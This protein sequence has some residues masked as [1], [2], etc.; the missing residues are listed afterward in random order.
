MKYNR[1]GGGGQKLDFGWMSLYHFSSKTYTLFLILTFDLTFTVTG[2][3][4]GDN[5]KPYCE[6]HYDQIFGVSC[7]VCGA[8]VKDNESGVGEAK[9]ATCCSRCAKHDGV[10]MRLTNGNVDKHVKD[11]VPMKQQLD[12]AL[13][14][15][16]RENVNKKVQSDLD[17]R[18][19][20]VESCVKEVA[21]YG[22]SQ[23][24]DKDDCESSIQ[25]SR[26][27][28]PST[29]DITELRR[30]GSFRRR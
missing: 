25:I 17:H 20:D 6:E 18:V 2:Y 28:I 14:Q 22:V 5:G 27:E 9:R 29:K 24:V 13:D 19:K 23:A 11:D 16:H 8:Y 7:L 3:Y 1:T 21:N 15:N 26:S 30:I 10:W 4:V 12:V